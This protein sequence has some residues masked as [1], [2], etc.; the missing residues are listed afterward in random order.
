MKARYVLSPEAVAD[1][2][3]IWN[4]IKEQTTLT[5][6]DR[7]ES[8]IPD[9]M[10]FLSRTSGAGHRRVDLTEEDVKF[11]SVYSYLLVYRAETRPLQI[12]FHSPRASRRATNPGYPLMKLEPRMTQPTTTEQ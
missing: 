6:A 9:R 12:V 3:E 7:V 8:A 4:Y 11:F 1:L 2:A 10:A 5:M